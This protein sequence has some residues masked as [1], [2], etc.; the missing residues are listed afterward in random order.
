MDLK[1]AVQFN[2]FI[3]SNVNGIEGFKLI[4]YKKQVVNGFNHKLTYED[5][6]GN[7]RAVILY[8]NIDGSI[9]ITD[10]SSVDKTIWFKWLSIVLSNYAKSSIKFCFSSNSSFSKITKQ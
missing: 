5:A 10:D 7:R 6:Q 9:S 4:S 2:D 3:Q 8:E 1:S